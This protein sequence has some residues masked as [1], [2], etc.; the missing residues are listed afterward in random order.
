MTG[1]KSFITLTADRQPE[2]VCGQERA[3]RVHP[4]ANQEDRGPSVQAGSVVRKR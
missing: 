4:E 2:P 3:E 1:E